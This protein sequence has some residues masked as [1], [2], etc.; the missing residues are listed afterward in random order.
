VVGEM[1]T[2][3]KVEEKQPDEAKITEEKTQEPPKL[4]PAT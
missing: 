4:E 3:E 2:E 1:K